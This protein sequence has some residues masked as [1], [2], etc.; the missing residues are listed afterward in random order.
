MQNTTLLHLSAAALS[1]ESTTRN[2]AAAALAAAP[3]SG[4]VEIP[5]G[6]RARELLLSTAVRLSGVAQSAQ[7]SARQLVDQAKKITESLPLITPQATDRP[8]RIATVNRAVSRLDVVLAMLGTTLEKELSARKA[9]SVAETIAG[10]PYA[11][12]E[13]EFIRLLARERKL[14]FTRSSVGPL[15]ASALQDTDIPGAY[16]LTFLRKSER[17]VAM[18]PIGS[19]T[20]RR[21]R[22][23]EITRHGE[24]TFGQRSIG[25][26]GPEFDGP[27]GRDPSKRLSPFRRGPALELVFVSREGAVQRD[28]LSQANF[29]EGAALVL[30]AVALSQ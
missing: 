11:V 27:K 23:G 29:E 17:I 5:E 3:T 1:L 7:T 24:R 25:F 4:D 6:L 15:V 2:L 19:P 9:D 18:H 28:T 21:R 22:E 13:T 20:K 14:T 26:H 16:A 8:V 10:T 30:N 12:A